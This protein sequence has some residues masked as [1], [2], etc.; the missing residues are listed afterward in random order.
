MSERELFDE[1]AR[2]AYELWERNGYIHGCDIEHWCEAESIV[3]SRM[4]IIQEEKP[5]KATAPRKTAAKITKKA[6]S[7]TAKT[8]KTAGTAK[9]V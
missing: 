6:S 2:V 1:I 9:K 4:Q 7:T 8:R 5:K 3:I